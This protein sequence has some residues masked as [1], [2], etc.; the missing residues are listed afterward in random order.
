[1]KIITMFSKRE[2]VVADDEAENVAK[3]SNG[4]GLLRLRSGDYISPKA[5]ESISEPKQVK[6]YK[7]YFVEKDGMSYIRD[8]EKIRIEH[9]ENIELAPDPKYIEPTKLLQ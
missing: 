6:M 2:Y 4:D 5:I 1:M 9:P 7:G 3:N 8:G